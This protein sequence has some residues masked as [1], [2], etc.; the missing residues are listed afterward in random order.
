MPTAIAVSP[1]N[2]FVYVGTATGVFLYNVNSDGTLTEGNNNN[3]VYLNLVVSGAVVV[4][5]MVVDPTNSWLLVA[6]QNSTDIDAVQLDP[7]TGIPTGNYFYA[8][9]TFATPNPQLAISAANATNPQVFVALGTGG[10]QV[11]GFNPSPAS[12]ANN[13]PWAPR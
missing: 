2:A 10:T 13:G 1:N 5:S 3:V 6:Y 9:S 8:T 11:F 7:T 12:T 4:Q